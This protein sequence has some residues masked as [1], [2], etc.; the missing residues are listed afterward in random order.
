MSTQT[1]TPELAIPV[2]TPVQKKVNI[3]DKAMSL[4][5]VRR[6]PSKSKTVADKSIIQTTGEAGMFSLSK[7]L[8]VCPEMKALENLEALLDQFLKGVAC[9]M[10]LKAGN[11]LVPMDLYLTVKAR[12]QEHEAKRTEL[13]NAF[14][15]VYDEAV[16]ESK[17]RLGDQFRATDYPPKEQIGSLFYFGYD[18]YDYS[19]SEKLKALDV[20]MAERQ[21]Q[22]IETEVKDAVE[23]H[24]HDLRKEMLGIVTHL[25]DRFTPKE[26][27]EGEMKRKVI[28]DIVLDK[29]TGFKELFPARNLAEDSKLE[30]I[31]NQADALLNGVSPEKIR[32][33][34]G[35]RDTVQ[36][37]FEAI[38]NSIDAL[39]VEEPS[40][41]ISFQ[42]L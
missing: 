9:S 18:W 30:E 37:G 14:V 26:N 4:S 15:A 24:K 20:E 38:R 23:V 12:L 28:R 40:R 8:W 35:V 2:P 36:K 17:Q 19:V 3:L 13:I 22:R 7:K 33:D 25:V 6:W 42:E 31:V 27:A 21:A 34:D 41:S 5:V 29:F 11:H 39:L 16:A 10:K 32:T 1:V